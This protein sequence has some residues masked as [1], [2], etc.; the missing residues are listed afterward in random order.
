MNEVSCVKERLI[1]SIKSFYDELNGRRKMPMMVMM[2][3]HG[4]PADTWRNNNVIMTSKRRRF[5]E[6]M[7]LSMRGVSAGNAFRITGPYG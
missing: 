3:W 6:I 2:A 5:D 1:W 7:T 4:N